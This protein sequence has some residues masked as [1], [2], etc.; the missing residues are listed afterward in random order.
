MRIS[1]KLIKNIDILS[2]IIIV[3]FVVSFLVTS[4]GWFIIMVNYFITK[5]RLM[6]QTYENLLAKDNI[7]DDGEEEK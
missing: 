4:V 3:V 5:G 1:L 7:N 2:K 6:R